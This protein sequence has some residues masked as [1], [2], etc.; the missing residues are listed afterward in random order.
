[1]FYYYWEEQIGKYLYCPAQYSW[2]G[3]IM[4]GI[5]PRTPV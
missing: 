2:V 4:P 3:F 5:S 1:M